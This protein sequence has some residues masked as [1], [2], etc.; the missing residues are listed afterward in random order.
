MGDLIAVSSSSSL[1]V[2][3]VQY[4]LPLTFSQE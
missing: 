1:P 3:I 4:I 2:F